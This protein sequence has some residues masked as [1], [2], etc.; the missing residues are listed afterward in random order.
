M[1]IK[2]LLYPSDCAIFIEFVNLHQMILDIFNK[3][4]SMFHHSW[5]VEIDNKQIDVLDETYDGDYFI[6]YLNSNIEAEN[7]SFIRLTLNL[8]HKASRWGHKVNTRANDI[9]QLT[10]VW[11]M[12]KSPDGKICKTECVIEND[13]TPE[14]YSKELHDILI[15]RWEN[16]KSAIKE[17]TTKLDIS[18]DFEGDVIDVIYVEEESNEQANMEETS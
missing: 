1:Y 12:V 7:I 3:R 11:R 15:P 13:Y 18:H 17:L 8:T 6:L 16:E 14:S 9:I 10:T 2:Q 5:N 4:T